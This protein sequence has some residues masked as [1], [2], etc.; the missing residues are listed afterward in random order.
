MH[1][2]RALDSQKV[3]GGRARAALS[4]LRSICALRLA[5]MDA[6]DPFGQAWAI[7]ES[8]AF[9]EVDT[10]VRSF[11]HRCMP[12]LRKHQ[13][14]GPFSAMLPVF[15]D[16]L[17]SRSGQVNRTHFQQFMD[18][19]FPAVNGWHAA[20]RLQLLSDLTGAK[21]VLQILR[22]AEALYRLLAQLVVD[23]AE[24]LYAFKLY[25]T[26][27]LPAIRGRLWTHKETCHIVA[28]HCWDLA[29][30]DRSI[31]AEA[32]EC[33]ATSCYPF[34]LAGVASVAPAA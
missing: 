31:I 14:D 2:L 10:F 12:K 27:Q 22:G 17:Q 15:V 25:E 23:K 29:V 28:M 7:F 6:V 30:R 9:V 33:A 20:V 26:Y 1:L 8:P 13:S 4:R 21:T 5:A 34:C 19:M 11:V 24:R 3:M 16:E 32:K 18:D